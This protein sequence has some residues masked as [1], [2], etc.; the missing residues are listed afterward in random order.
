MSEAGCMTDEKY[1]RNRIDSW[2]CYDKFPRRTRRFVL[3]FNTML[4]VTYPFQAFLE[5]IK[6][7]FMSKKEIAAIKA[8]AKEFDKILED[9]LFEGYG[10]RPND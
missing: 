10:R 2:A 3:H 5:G 8:H 6:F 4:N 7:A 1:W 9:Y